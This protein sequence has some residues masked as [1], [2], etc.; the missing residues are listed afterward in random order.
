MAIFGYIPCSA[1]IISSQTVGH[2]IE[3]VNIIS[4]RAAKKQTRTA[5]ALP[6]CTRRGD[7]N[8]VKVAVEPPITRG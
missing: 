1:Q 3:L 5:G 4:W 6:G 8:Q 7:S 2:G